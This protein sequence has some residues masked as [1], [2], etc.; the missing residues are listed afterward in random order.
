MRKSKAKADN[1]GY[2]AANNALMQE[3]A[4]HQ[5]NFVTNKAEDCNVVSSLF[6]TNIRLVAEISAANATLAVAVAEIAAL[7]VRLNGICTGRRC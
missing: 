7:R 6:E 1:K 2:G 3:T 4:T 5:E